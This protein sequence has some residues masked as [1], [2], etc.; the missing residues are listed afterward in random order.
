MEFVA[1]N[2]VQA[3]LRVHKESIAA[4]GVAMC[5]Y[6]L[7][8]LPDVMEKVVQLRSDIL[9]QLVKWVILAGD[10]IQVYC[11]YVMWLLH[12]SYE[13][14]QSHATLFFQH[15]LRFRTILDRFDEADGLRKLDN[16]VR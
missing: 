11:S 8:H 6:Y 5:L 16:C 15:A 1:R 10:L 7:A 4:H 13:S 9:N 2:G 12:H 3:L 14:A